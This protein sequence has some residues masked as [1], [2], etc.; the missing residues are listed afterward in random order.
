[1]KRVIFALLVIAAVSIPALAKY[2]GGSGEPN[3]PYQIATKA[4][5]LVLAA[6]ANDY[7]KCF[8]LTA[9]INMTGQ[10]FTTAIIA[11]DTS[12]EH[13]FQGTPFTGEFDGNVHKIANFTINGG[14]NYYLGLFGDINSGGSVKNLGLENCSV[15][16]SSTSSYA[17]GLVGLNNGSISNCGSTGLVSGGQYVGGLVG[18]NNYGNIS[19]CYST[20]TVSG[21]YYVGGLV[22]Y[23]NYGSISNCYSTGSVIIPSY[24]TCLGVGGLVGWNN[25]GSISNCY[26]TGLVNSPSSSGI[27]DFGGLVGSNYYGSIS[28]CFS[29]GAVVI[30]VDG[31][32][33][34]VGGL[35]GL[36]SN[37]SSISNC[38]STGLVRVS[39][40]SP[41]FAIG[42]LVGANGGSIVSSF[43]DTQTSGQT[44]G[45]GSG[46]SVGCSGK[47]MVQMRTLL[48]FT[49]TGWDFVEIWDIVENQTYP[50]LR[51]ELT[52]D[53]NHDKKVD[54][55]DFAIFAENWLQGL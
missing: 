1:M 39:S 27:I 15:S 7:N 33:E 8:I 53:L 13:Y 21:T 52:G 16:G 24:L 14:N 51:T 29:M 46:S 50:Y 9:D 11:A 18:Y 34:Y 32:S 17:G 36:N 55:V 23:N 4:D 41:P 28:N 54:F 26:S 19:N 43:W 35:V 20:S 48:I 2:S 45:V 22:G 38:G 3:T 25:G 40:S 31:Y 47:T 5:L 44:I 49:S 12:S 6:D 10:V 30:V 42:G 37:S